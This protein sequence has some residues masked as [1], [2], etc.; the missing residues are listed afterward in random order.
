MNEKMTVLFV[1]Y[2]LIYTL[3]YVL[4]HYT[5]LNDEMYYIYS[6]YYHVNLHI[7][8]KILIL[9]SCEM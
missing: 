3:L 2:I 5:L 6:T 9:E 4:I 7:N 1:L 8:T